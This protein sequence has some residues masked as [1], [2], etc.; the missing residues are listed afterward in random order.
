M[1][2]RYRGN[3]RHWWQWTARGVINEG[4]RS[5]MSIPEV[6]I[7]E[8]ADVVRRPCEDVATFNEAAIMIAHVKDVSCILKP[9]NHASLTI[10]DCLLHT[11]IILRSH[12]K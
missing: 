4:H 11:P 9:T 3:L 6:A 5:A 2:W 8:L 1:N 7:R 12:Q 10:E